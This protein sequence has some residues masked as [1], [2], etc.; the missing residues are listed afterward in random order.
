MIAG[1]NYR[2]A[3]FREA[4]NRGEPL[5]TGIRKYAKEKGRQ[6]ASMNEL[7][8]AYV[9]A[10]PATGIIRSPQFS[11][12]SRVSNAS[13]NSN[14]SMLYLSIPDFFTEWRCLWWS[15]DGRWDPSPR[16]TEFFKIGEWS[17]LSGLPKI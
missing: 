8:P 10:I 11:Y 2:R 9:T 17:V 15:S 16:M 6:P 4:A 12:V 1:T 7:V 13:G 5:I 14:R 3:K